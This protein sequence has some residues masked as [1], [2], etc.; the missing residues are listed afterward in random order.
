LGEKINHLN[1]KKTVSETIGQ[2][3]LAYRTLLQAQEELKLAQTSVKRADALVD[4]NHALIDAGRMASV[5]IVQSEADVENQKIRVLEATKSL[6]DAR[7]A[8]LELLSLDLGTLLIA[9]ESTEPK[10]IKPELSNMMRI[11]LDE[12]PDYL[13][14]RFIVE[15]NKLGI[16]VA[17][18]QRLW[19]LSVFAT[20]S[21]GRQTTT[22]ASVMPVGQKIADTT[23]GVSLNI[24]LNDLRREQP[25]VQ[26]TT[27]LK[28]SELQLATIRQGV[29]LQ[30][31]GSITDVDIRW[32]QY[33]VA[34]RARE[35][36]IRAVDIEK[37]KLKVGRSSNFQVRSL[38]SDLRSAEEQQLNAVIGYLNALT[39]LDIQLGTTLKTWRI[40]LA[41]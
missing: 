2:V 28:T 7:L 27:T 36:A 23:V 20:G 16:V 17:D 31:R 32:R 14:Q 18:N 11:A 3:I 30:V 33:E 5:E 9:G 39:T 15:Q 38:E 13:G 37:E 34:R 24:P 10:R 22:G 1:L 35:L 25:A 41:D 4:M 19:D 12:R 21:F 6:D 8:L 40:S 29:E 26:A